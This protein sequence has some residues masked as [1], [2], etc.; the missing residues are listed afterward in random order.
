MRPT[1]GPP[2]VRAWRSKRC[3]AGAKP[4]AKLRSG[5]HFGAGRLQLH[6]RRWVAVP[7]PLSHIHHPVLTDVP[8]PPR[9][10]QAKTSRRASCAC[11]AEG[12]GGGESGGEG[13]GEG[14]STKATSLPLVFSNL[15]AQAMSVEKEAWTDFDQVSYES[16]LRRRIE[17]DVLPEPEDCARWLAASPRIERARPSSPPPPTPPPPPYPPPRTPPSTEVPCSE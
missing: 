12:G 7:R 5:A 15:L 4:G 2:P 8:A 13:G 9:R 11:G 1:G 16:Q 17:C 6:C 14:S 10:M 3:A